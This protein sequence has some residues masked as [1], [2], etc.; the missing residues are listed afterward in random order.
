MEV[1]TTN[2]KSNAGDDQNSM[3]VQAFSEYPDVVTVEQMAQMLGVGRKTAYKIV[4]DGL[5]PCLMVGRI[6][7]IPKQN[8]LKYLKIL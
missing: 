3:V 7:R 8:I 2:K 5:I 4:N 1:T 6:Y